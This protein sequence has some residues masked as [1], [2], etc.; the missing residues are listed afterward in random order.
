MGWGGLPQD[1]I[2]AELAAKKLTAIKTPLIKER[3]IEIYMLRDA[4]KPMG[5]VM[6]ELWDGEGF[7]RILLRPN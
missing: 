3:D 4:N 2:K 1:I 5:P 7:L 6:K